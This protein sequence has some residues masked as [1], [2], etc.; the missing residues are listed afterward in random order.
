MKLCRVFHWF[1]QAKF[2]YGGSFLKLSQFTTA[3]AA[4]KTKLSLKV[5]KINFKKS[6]S[7]C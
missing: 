6:K 1:G 2:A 4:S 5:V 7:L 3:P